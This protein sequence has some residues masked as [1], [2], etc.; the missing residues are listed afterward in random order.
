MPGA[1]SGRGRRGE[2]D[3]DRAVSGKDG[4][5]GRAVDVAHVDGDAP[6]ANHGMASTHGFLLALA[7]RRRLPALIPSITQW[8]H[9]E[10]PGRSRQR[11]LDLPSKQFVM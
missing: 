2:G 7:T 3:Q 1:G 4:E 10:F 5:V 8:G 6:G 11:A 9:A